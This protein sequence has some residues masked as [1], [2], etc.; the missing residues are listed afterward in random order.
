MTDPK[1]APPYHGKTSTPWTL[2]LTDARRAS[3]RRE[4]SQRPPSPASVARALALAEHGTRT[5]VRLCEAIDAGRNPL[6]D[7]RDPNH[8]PHPPTVD[9]HL[10]RGGTWTPNPWRP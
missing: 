5:A 9:L 1:H 2:T 4:P 3:L 8:K 10:L 7:P 6:P